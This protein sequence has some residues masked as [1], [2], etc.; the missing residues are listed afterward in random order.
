MDASLGMELMIVFD[1]TEAKSNTRV[2]QAVLDSS[3]IIDGLEALTGADVLISPLSSP[4]LPDKLT[5][6]IPHRKMLEVHTKAGMLAQRKDGRDLLSSI[7]D[8]DEILARMLEWTGKV[9]PVLLPIGLY[10]RN[11]NG[12]V[13]VGPKSTRWNY[14]SLLGA[15]T[16][17]QS[18]GGRIDWLSDVGAL[19]SWLKMWHD[20][21]LPGLASG[22]H[23]VV[24]RTTAQKLITYDKWW[25]PLVTLR[26][27]GPEK[28]KVLAEWLPEHR[29][30]L[31]HAIVYLCDERNQGLDKPP[32]FGPKT[33]DAARELFGLEDNQVLRLISVNG[34]DPKHYPVIISWPPESKP[35]T[36]DGQWWQRAD[37]ATEA[38][39]NSQSEL[40]T[41]L[42]MM[43]VIEL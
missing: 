36:I 6:A 30:T 25:T 26:N 4:K 42:Q 29:R 40:L 9:A 43:G 16:S 35:A 31:A 19:P 1:A 2:P 10:T 24:R 7:S 32:G 12:K 39:Y 3:Q 33:F 11:K 5:G 20:V 34:D 13:K 18:R 22:T 37:G 21:H 28:A 17:W 41:C 8:L 27:I 15:M 38:I 14:S 23:M